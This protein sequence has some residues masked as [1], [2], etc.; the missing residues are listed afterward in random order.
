[1][2]HQAQSPGVSA[3]PGPWACLASHLGPIPE[4]DEGRWRLA[5]INDVRLAADRR[6]V[7]FVQ[8]A[9][10]GATVVP[11]NADKGAD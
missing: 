11:S 8:T 9:P 10:G 7:H 5:F 4:C 3:Q 2:S 6:I 1:L